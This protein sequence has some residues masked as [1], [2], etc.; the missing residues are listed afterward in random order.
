MEAL[1]MM[2]LR[3]KRAEISE[4][5]ECLGRHVEQH[6][7]DL[8]HLDA[9]LRLFDPEAEAAT[10]AKGPARKRNDWFQPGECRRRIHDVLRD[11]AVIQ[12]TERHCASHSPAARKSN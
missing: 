11:A 1:V 9:T 6:R 8:T 3:A 5:L 7:V 10:G 2:N 4:T 12:S